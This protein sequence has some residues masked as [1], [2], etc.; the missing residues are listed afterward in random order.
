MMPRNEYK[1]CT[2]IQSYHPQILKEPPVHPDQLVLRKP[3]QFKPA[4]NLKV[5]NWTDHVNSATYL[6]KIQFHLQHIFCRLLCTTDHRDI[7]PDLCKCT[8]SIPFL[9]Q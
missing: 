7:H 9:L 6:S 8:S 5:Y 3:R 4:M 2:S 1:R